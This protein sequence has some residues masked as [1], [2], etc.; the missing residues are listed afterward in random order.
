MRSEGVPERGLEL[1]ETRAARNVAV[2]CCGVLRRCHRS[3]IGDFLV[4]AGSDACTSS[5]SGSGTAK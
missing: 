2:M 5:R 3:M 4:Y 1:V